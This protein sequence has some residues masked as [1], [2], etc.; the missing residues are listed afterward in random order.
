M[1]QFIPKRA[2]FVAGFFVFL[3]A[4]S[5]A[6]AEDSFVAGADALMAERAQAFVASFRRLAILPEGEF[7]EEWRAERDRWRARLRALPGYEAG[8]RLA[9]RYEAQIRYEWAIGRLL[10]PE[11]YGGY[12]DNPEFKP[13]AGYDAYLEALDLGRGDWLDLPEYAAFLVRKRNADAFSSVEIPEEALKIGV[14][15]LAAKRL[16]NEAFAD[17]AVRCFLE[18][19]ALTDWIENFAADGLTNEANEIAG[20]CPG[21]QSDKLLAMVAAERAERAGHPI[22]RYKSV[23]GTDLE[24]HL[25]RSPEETDPVPAI[26]WLHGGGW[27]SGSWSWCGACVWFKERGLAVAQVEYRIVG[28]HGSTI[29]VSYADAIDAIAWVRAH[30]DELGVDPDRVAAA[31]FSAGGHLSLAAATFEKAGS[32]RPD[33][34]ISISGCTDLTNDGYTV[35]HAG[36]DEKAR[37]LSPRYAPSAAS[38]AMFI[39]NAENDDTCSFAEASDFAQAASDAGADVTFFGVPGGGHFF[40]RDPERA[41][42]TKA[43]VFKFLD[44]NGF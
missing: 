17:D 8:S 6:C 33:L 9:E 36:G 32:K 1:M 2:T 41:A 18:R 10:Y 27:Y 31:G 22:K 12:T 25:F 5:A 35:L 7:V 23:N 24:L 13:S 40:L 15:D 19:E 20:A 44:D 26:V 3:A 43:A 37:A 42:E 39:A 16:A 4:T 14:R 21:P 30:A 29:G 38:P 11:F 34:A 28:R